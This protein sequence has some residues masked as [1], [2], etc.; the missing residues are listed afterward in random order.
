MMP[1]KRAI[2][3]VAATLAVV[4]GAAL[5]AALPADA[6]TPSCGTG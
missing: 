1:A 3:A 4:G 6:E 2:A 5:S